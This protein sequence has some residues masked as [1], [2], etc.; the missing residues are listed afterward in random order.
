MQKIMVF[1]QNGSGESKISGINRFS[2]SRFAV[3]IINIDGEL[4]AFIDDPFPYLQDS[5]EAD[6]VLDYLKHPDLSGGLSLLCK[7]LDLPLIASGK[8]IK[9]GSAVCP[10]T[11]C[12]LAGRERFG[13]YGR[14][15]G[16]PEIEVKMEGETVVEIT[17]IRGAPCGANWRAAQ[18]IK[19]M[20]VEKALTRFG[21]EVQLFCTANPASWDPI[22]GKSPVHLAADIHTAALRKNLA[23]RPAQNHF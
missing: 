11:C 1:Q 20:P 9:T 12:P 14:V 15:F 19:N 10:T 21:L 16:L 17:V 18:K 2:S 22:G 7:G 3:T 6:L 5:I 4:P 13:D 23:Q 8:K